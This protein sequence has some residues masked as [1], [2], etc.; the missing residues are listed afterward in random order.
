[1]EAIW[2][3]DFG[4]F[5]CFFAVAGGEYDG[6]HGW[7]PE[8]FSGERGSVSENGEDIFAEVGGD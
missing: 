8:T 2:S 4:D 1:L 5:L 7:N 6:W 3:K